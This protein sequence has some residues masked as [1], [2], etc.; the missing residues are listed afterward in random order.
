[1]RYT[2]KDC[3]SECLHCRRGK[4]EPNSIGD[5][6]GYWCSFCGSN[7]PDGPPLVEAEFTE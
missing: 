3:G 2:E 1:M 7:S 6:I 4:I 5:G